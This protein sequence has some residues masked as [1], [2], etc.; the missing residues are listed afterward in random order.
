MS[1]H[2]SADQAGTPPVRHR[3]QCSQRGT[4]L[5]GC[6]RVD[7]PCPAV[8]PVSA[9]EYDAVLRRLS[10]AE[11]TRDNMSRQIRGAGEKNRKLVEAIT[12]MRYQVERLRASL[13]QNVMPPLNSAI[14]LA[15]HEGQTMTYEQVASAAESRRS[16]ASYSCALTG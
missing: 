10:A 3:P 15:V 16:T 11:A 2:E 7:L 4:A 6:F 13:S 14:V 9:Q 1:T 12:S 5:L 8:S